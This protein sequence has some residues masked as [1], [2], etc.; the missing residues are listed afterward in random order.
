M[1]DY[2]PIREYRE[3]RPKMLKYLGPLFK[4]LNKFTRDWVFSWSLRSWLY[5]LMG[6]RL[7]KHSYIARET[8]IDDNFP[9]LVTINEGVVIGWRCSIIAHN[10]QMMPP[11][12]APVHI[13]RH[14]FLGQGVVVMPGVTIGEYAQIGT[15]SLV[16]K[17]I[18]PY[19]V[20]A[21]TPAKPIRK[22]TQDEIDLRNSPVYMG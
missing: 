17:D 13:K 20:A 21:G 12:V 9:E 22:L 5:R 14:A 2:I 6:V 7:S 3:R 10:T 4:V 1:V 8:W 18:E 19:T 11:S 15:N 16:T